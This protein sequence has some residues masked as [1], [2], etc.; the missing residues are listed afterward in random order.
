MLPGRHPHVGIFR[1]RT[2]WAVGFGDL[3]A[4]N[5]GV[6]THYEVLGVAESAT[7]VEVRAAY[8]AAARRQHPDSGGEAEA[9]RR[10]N[11]AWRVLQDSGR[12]AAYDR[13]LAR[14]RRPATPS[15]PSPGSGGAAG[16]GPSGVEGWLALLPPASGAFAVALFGAGWLFASPALFVFAVGALFM[17]L[18]LFVLVPL[19]AMLRSASPRTRTRRED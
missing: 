3:S 13:E 15:A 12:R 9:M 8:W 17:S 5:G 16:A 14:Q 18:C 10:L 19:L 2:L 4:Q 6:T 11:E 7:E 1:A